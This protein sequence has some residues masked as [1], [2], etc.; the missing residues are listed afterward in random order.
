MVKVLCIPCR[1]LNCL[2]YERSVIRMDP[3]E[4]QFY[5]WFRSLVVLEDSKGLLRPEDLAGGKSP[6]EAP[7]V[8]ERLSFR[9]VCFVSPLGTLTGNKNAG[10]ILQGNG[11]QQLVLLSVGCH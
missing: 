8:T 5:G 9:Q 6:A 2:F 4:N 1:T 10:G 3:S 7:C 11:S